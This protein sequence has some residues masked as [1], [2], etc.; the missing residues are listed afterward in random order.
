MCM[1]G[2]FSASARNSCKDYSHLYFI[3]FIPSDKARA[4]ARHHFDRE[5][6]AVAIISPFGDLNEAAHTQDGPK[7]RSRTFQY[8]DDLRKTTR[9]DERTD[10]EIENRDRSLT[11]RGS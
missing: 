6:S 8:A 5:D 4:R 9:M 1:F 11:H 10:I 2:D 7:N 3:S